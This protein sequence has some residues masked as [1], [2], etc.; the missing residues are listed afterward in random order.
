MHVFENQITL[1]TS[2]I[3]YGG[4]WLLEEIQ[5]VA[6]SDAGE[7]TLEFQIC[8]KRIATFYM[9]NVL[10]II[11]LLVLLGAAFVAMEPHDFTGRGT[12]SMT[13]MLTI[14]AF[15]FVMNS[16]LPIVSYLTWLDYYMIIALCLISSTILFEFFT[17]RLF[18]P[19]NSDGSRNDDAERNGKIFAYVY[20]GFWVLLNV[21]IVF[22][23]VFNLFFEDWVV[24]RKRCEIG[25]TEHGKIGVNLPVLESA[26]R[27]LSL[28]NKKEQ[29]ARRLV[30][31]QKMK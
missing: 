2:Y 9:F 29:A 5:C 21:V 8:V 31:Q 28:E 3:Y 26:G 20:V 6:K 30:D 4:D 17:S 12:Y 25:Y 22:G 15:K 10:L 11:F 7:S 19:P 23:H 24:A 13:V 1:S 18:F 27:A 14:V 16:F